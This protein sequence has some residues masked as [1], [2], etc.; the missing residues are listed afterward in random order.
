MIYS[1]D[2]PAKGYKII[3]SG[4]C[5]KGPQT[6]GAYRLVVG[7]NA[8]E[9]L[10]GGTTERGNPVL[11]DPTVVRVGLK[12][13]QITF[14]DQVGENFGAVASLMMRWHDPALAYDPASCNCDFKAYNYDDFID[15]AVENSLRW[16]EFTVYNQQERRWEQNKVVVLYPDGEAIYFERFW[17]K[18]QAPDFDFRKYPFDT[19]N[20][21]IRIDSLYGDRFYVYEILEGFSE[22]GDQLGEEEWLVINSS[23]EVT[24]EISST[25]QPVSRFTF[26]FETVR[27]LNYYIFRIFIPIIILIT[28]SWF[29]FFLRDYTKRIE[30]ASANLL[31]FVAFNFTI[32]NDIPRLGYM[33]IMDWVLITTFA[34][35]GMSVL[36]N[37]VLKLLEVKGKTDLAT[38]IDNWVSWI[39]P[40]F[41]IIVMI[42]I[43]LLFTDTKLF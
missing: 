13:Q 11:L 8:P 35:T 42:N 21:Y 22:V 17:S 7:L 30:A 34:V 41:Y 23:T 6:T 36:I 31:I 2:E 40:I 9:V 3:V 24:T 10:S 20:F 15:F 19:Q 29:I 32:S 4:C 43:F 25:G 1:F 33:T 37:V 14:V 12:L 28:I 27:H 38:R 26:G 5:P 39:Y 16:P 18:L